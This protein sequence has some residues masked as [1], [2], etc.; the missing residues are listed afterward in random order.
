[1]LCQ[2]PQSAAAQ[3]VAGKLEHQPAQGRRPQSRLAR[4]ELPGPLRRLD[5]ASPVEIYRFALEHFT[6]ISAASV[7][8]PSLAATMKPVTTG[9]AAGAGDYN[10]TGLSLRDIRDGK[11]E[12]D[13]RR[14]A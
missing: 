2:T 6:A 5:A 8:I 7:A 3:P 12:N 1:M 13:V 10:Y 14:A 11:V 9:G 4:G